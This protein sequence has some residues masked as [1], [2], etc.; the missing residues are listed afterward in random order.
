MEKIR[1]VRVGL[2]A[3]RPGLDAESQRRREQAGDSSA[4]QRRAV[5]STCTGSAHQKVPAASSAAVAIW[6]TARTPVGGSGETS[7][8]QNVERVHYRAAGH[9]QVARG[10]YRGFSG[11]SSAPSRNPPP[12]PA[13]RPSRNFPVDQAAEDR[14][15]RDVEAGD[16]S[17]L[18]CRREFEAGGLQHVAGEEA[19]PAIR[20]PRSGAREF[21][22]SK[23]L[24]EIRTRAAV[25]AA[26]RMARNRSV[27]TSLSACL[28]R[29]NVAPQMSATP[30]R[31][32]STSQPDGLSPVILH[33]GSRSRACGRV[34]APG[35][36]SRSRSR[37]SRI[38]FSPNSRPSG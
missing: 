26:K 10:R 15:Q 38:R 6:A 32:R 23:F 37:V 25:A 34:R 13:V 22:L 21:G 24:A 28:T 17:G 27:E 12:L 31:L 9:Q 11:S 18:R 36:R 16:E 33:S 7:Q 4:I 29:M 35:A 5:H 2:V 19:Q 20:P 30:M 8:H 14:H 1:A 3:L